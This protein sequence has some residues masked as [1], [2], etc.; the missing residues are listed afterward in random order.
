[1]TK[2]AELNAEEDRKRKEAVETKNQLDSVTYQIGKGL[3]DAGD[4]L[5]ADKKTAIEAAISDAKQDLEAT[6]ARSMKSGHGE[7][8]KPSAPNSMP[9][10]PKPV[11]LQGRRYRMQ[12]RPCQPKEAKKTEKK[13]DVVDA[14]FEVVDDDKNK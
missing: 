10:P 2:E 14:D 8:L 11:R 9:P 6:T 1:M 4:K 3:K 5:P 13:A 7:S 12:V